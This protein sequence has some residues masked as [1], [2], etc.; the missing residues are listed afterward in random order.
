MAEQKRPCTSCPKFIY[1][2][3]VKLW[4]TVY[5]RYKY[6]PYSYKFK[7]DFSQDVRRYK[8]ATIRYI[9]KCEIK[10]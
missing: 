5:L 9:E 4:T 7:K 6:K 3:E 1:P 8:E 10:E 2:G